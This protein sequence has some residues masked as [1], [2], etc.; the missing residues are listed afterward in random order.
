MTKKPIKNIGLFGSS[1]NPP[2]LGHWAV[3]SDLAKRAVFDE[4]WLVPVYKHPFDKELA[5]YE[6]RL[7]MVELLWLDLDQDR[8]KISTIEKELGR[9][10]TYTYD[11]VRELKSCYPDYDFSLIVGSDAKNELKKWHRYEDLKDLV[12]FYFIPRKGFENSPYPDVSSRGI[13]EAIKKG[14][15]IDQLTTDKVAGYLKQNKIYSKPT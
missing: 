2:H 6:A 14:E 5:P 8:I 12:R 4:I 3:L 10:P 7:K 13:R 11:V 9:E 15:S 1:F